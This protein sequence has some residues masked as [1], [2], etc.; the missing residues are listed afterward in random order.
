MAR[1]DNTLDA[2]GFDPTLGSLDPQSAFGAGP[3]ETCGSEPSGSFV[4]DA[5]T[6]EFFGSRRRSFEGTWCR[7]CARAVGRDAQNRTLRSGWFGLTAWVT[8]VRTVV[9]NANQLRAVARLA[10]SPN[11]KTLDGG[12][13]VP[14]RSTTITAL[15]VAAIVGGGLYAFLSDPTRDV[16]DLVVGDCVLSPGNQLYLDT[17]ETTSCDEPHDFEVYAVGTI[18]DEG[19]NVFPGAGRVT[20]RAEQGC[21]DA[22]A[23]YVGA[24]YENSSLDFSYI[25]PTETGW[26]WG[27]EDYHCLVSSP[28]GPLTESVR[29]S[30][31]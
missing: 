31:R 11:D 26:L 18:M 21:Y 15:I 25:R 5:I 20:T 7:G 1:S 13:P 23:P 4:F 24:P 19:S 22:F 29:G 2:A 9:D 6:A 30:G 10:S 14:L 8:N 28:D 12:R 3:C 27:D 17:V 16:G